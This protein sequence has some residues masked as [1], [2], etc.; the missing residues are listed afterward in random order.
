MN[1]DVLVPND[2]NYEV[3]LQWLFQGMMSTLP[4]T[5]MILSARVIGSITNSHGT[6]GS[7]WIPLLIV[8]FVLCKLLALLLNNP[9]RKC[10]H[11][12]K[13]MAICTIANV[14]CWILLVCLLAF[15]NQTH[16]ILF[17]SLYATVSVMFLSTELMR[18]AMKQLAQAFPDHF[19]KLTRFGT[20]FTPTLGVALFV[21]LCTC[22]NVSLSLIQIGVLLWC[23]GIALTFS[24]AFAL[25]RLQSLP[26]Y[27]WNY[28][29]LVVSENA[30]LYHMSL[31]K[32][33]E[34]LSMQL[35]VPFMEHADAG[36]IKDLLIAV[37]VNCFFAS[38]VITCVLSC[39]SIESRIGDVKSSCYY[40]YSLLIIIGGFVIGSLL[41]LL[42]FMWSWL[43]S[44]NR[45]SILLLILQPMLCAS[46][47][48]GPVCIGGIRLPWTPLYTDGRVALAL[49][50]AASMIFA[51]AYHQVP[52]T[53]STRL[54][55]HDYEGQNRVARILAMVF[56]SSVLVGA[57]VII[58]LQIAVHKT[59]L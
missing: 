53:A 52:L 49:I 29:Q 9:I 45:W 26:Y 31:P 8:S 27:K 16:V 47:A 6:L 39:T 7:Y 46:L 57:L 21:L 18:S 25:F 51:V 28:Q 10:V 37:F 38:I 59:V 20:F 13:I 1:A 4:I 19:P 30:E 22:T 42:N 40:S 17:W 23:V 55:N 58:A 5:I 54:D 2:R 43:R 15:F 3:S 32:L 33:T 41:S 11:P 14:I 50:A 24:S 12:M 44:T 56:Y 36:V 34:E 48:I 35:R